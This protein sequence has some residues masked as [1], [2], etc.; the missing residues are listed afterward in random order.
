MIHKDSHES[1]DQDEKVDRALARIERRL[2]RIEQA[3][4]HGAGANGSAPSEQP[5][6]AVGTPARS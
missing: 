6:V 5:H 4:H 1:K 2:E 3:R